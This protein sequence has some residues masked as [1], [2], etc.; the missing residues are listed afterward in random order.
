[1]CVTNK[2]NLCEFFCV[3]GV[4]YSETGDVDKKYFQQVTPQPYAFMI[5]WPIIFFL[6]LLGIC[7]IA[8]SLCLPEY[9]SMVKVKP[10]LV[11]KVK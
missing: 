8:A 2:Q 10:T 6:N 11:P 9:I 5:I 7:Y 4:F 3:A 1:M